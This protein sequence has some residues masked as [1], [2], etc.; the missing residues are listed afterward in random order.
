MAINAGDMGNGMG[1]SVVDAPKVGVLLV[2]A[3]PGVLAAAADLLCDEFSVCTAV[4]AASALKILD[5]Q[6]MSVILTGYEPAPADQPT[7]DF[8]A[9]VRAI[10]DATR[11]LVL[12]SPSG[13]DDVYEMVERG[14]VHAGLV[15]PWHPHEL[16]VCVRSA[17]DRCRLRGQ[18]EEERARRLRA[19]AEGE[20]RAHAALEAAEAASRAKTVFLANMSHELRT[21]LNAIIG[22]ADLIGATMSDGEQEKFGA[23]VENISD[24]AGHLLGIINDILDV[25]RIEVGKVTLRE[26]DVDVGEAIQAAMRLVG[27]AAAHKQQAL[28][29][30]I[31]E[32]FPRLKADERLVKQ[33]LTNIIANASKYTLVDGHV[34]V[35]AE[36]AN[37]GVMI[38]VE[39]NGVGIAAKDLPMVLQPFGQAENILSHS[40]EGSG[41]GLPL[42]KGFME[43]H[44]G[45]LTLHSSVGEGTRVDLVFPPSRT[46]RALAPA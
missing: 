16:K 45:T 23:Y 44:G 33:I 40:E 7:L 43:L 21:P 41:L 20:D 35:R 38:S 15:K 17:A 2:D 5:Q 11:V 22:F 9:R 27:P 31:S 18:L 4:D 34:S 29:F 14:E 32:G 12:S 39:D 26:K 8:L 19:L 24:S 10:S 13:F 30:T 3:D 25:S 37:G 28:S 6:E 46:V 36:M 42:A 1:A